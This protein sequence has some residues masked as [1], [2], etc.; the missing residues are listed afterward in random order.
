MADAYRAAGGAGP[1]VLV[2]RVSVGA[3]SVDRH[4]KQVDLYRSYTTEAQQS[5]WRGDQMIAGDPAA[6]AAELTADLAETGSDSLNLRVHVPDV[7]P[8]E[9]LGHIA[10]L[11]EVLRLL[12][13]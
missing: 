1:I 2:R 8:N 13:S 4:A 6:I 12:R 5:K 11:A 3:S 10:G 7:S 9:A